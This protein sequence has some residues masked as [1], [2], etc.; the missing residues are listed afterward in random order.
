MLDQHGFVAETNA[1]NLFAIRD[2][3]LYTSHADA[4]LPGITRGVVLE[5]AE[6][7]DIPAVEKN[8]SL[9]EVYTADQVFVTGTMGELTSV[10]E[11]DGRKI[12]NKSGMDTLD[13]IQDMYRNMTHYQGDIF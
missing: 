7:L 2:E 13:R 6:E 12:V 10:G 9:T 1:T 3:V 4:C 8:L 5:I 11:V